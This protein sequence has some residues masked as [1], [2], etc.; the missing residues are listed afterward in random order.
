LQDFNSFIEFSLKQLEDKYDLLDLFVIQA[1]Q[2][3]QKRSTRQL[4]NASN[5]RAFS[6]T[7]LEIGSIKHIH[8]WCATGEELYKLPGFMEVIKQIE[9]KE[10]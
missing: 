3:L 2:E 8:Y 5:P 4:E 7:L 1:C 10:I 9:Q 6:L